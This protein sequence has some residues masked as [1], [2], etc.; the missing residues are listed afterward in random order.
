MDRAPGQEGAAPVL[1]DES[2]RFQ[3]PVQLE[4]AVDHGGD[5]PAAH[6][7]RARPAE[8]R[9]R[10]VPD[11]LREAARRLRDVDADAEHGPV[12]AAAF[13]VDRGLGQNAA[14]L[15]AVQVNV[16]HPLD[17]R[18]QRR[19]VLDRPAHGDRGRRRD[20]QRALGRAGRAQQEAEIDARAGRRLELPP[21]AP[22][23]R[24][25]GFGDQHEPLLCAL[26]RLGLQK[27]VRRGHGAA[28]IEPHGEIRRQIPRNAPR[29]EHVAVGAQ[30]VAA[31]RHGVDP[32]PV[33]LEL[34]DRLPDRVARHAERGGNLLAR[35]VT[36]AV[37][38]QIVQNC[39][40]YAHNPSSPMLSAPAF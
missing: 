31:L 29:R 18:M 15:P 21:E 30:R 38:V 34:P 17:L 14:D 4:K 8:Q 1:V 2:A 28:H 6:F 13:K 12:E 40:L 3:I 37:P 33:R 27:G 11:L 26:L 36:A 20:E 35:N 5:Q 32:V 19:H 9:A 25:L 24:R 7:D 39:I 16:V 23:A 22:L 10:R